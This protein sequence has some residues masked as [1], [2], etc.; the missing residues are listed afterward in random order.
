M[1]RID[2]TAIAQ[3]V[4][5]GNEG[6]SRFSKGRFALV[7]RLSSSAMIQLRT[8][9]RVKDKKARNWACLGKVTSCR[10]SPSPD[11]LIVRDSTNHLFTASSCSRRFRNT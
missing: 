7:W 6:A 4:H 2:G 9:V 10:H 1:K 5:E 11:S 8:Y 3:K